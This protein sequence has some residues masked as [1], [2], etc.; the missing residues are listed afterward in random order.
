MSAV[1]IRTIPPHYP[2]R[3][4]Q[5]HETYPIDKCIIT[6]HDA[7]MKTLA[8]TVLD[9]VDAFLERH[10]MAATTLGRLAVNDGHAIHDLRRGGNCTIDRV[11]KL[12]QFMASYK[13]DGKPRPKQPA[14][15]AAA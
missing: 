11:D 8:Q 13:P 1:L 4:A 5:S 6:H 7:G 2:T 12:R 9:E 15:E 3:Y 10:N 14:A